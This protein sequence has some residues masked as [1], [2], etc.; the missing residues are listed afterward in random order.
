LIGTPEAIGA[1][2]RAYKDGWIGEFIYSEIEALG[3]PKPWSS[4]YLTLEYNLDLYFKDLN[5]LIVRNN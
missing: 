1:V 5:A 4:E 2:E 3:N